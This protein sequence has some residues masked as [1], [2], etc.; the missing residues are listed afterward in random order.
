MRFVY[1]DE[2]KEFIKTKFQDHS[3]VEVTRMFNEKFGLDKTRNQLK[4]MANN[5]GI[6]CGGRRGCFGYRKTL[7]TEE[8]MAFVEREYQDISRDDLL[9]RLNAKYDLSL[10]INQLIAFLKNNKITSGRTGRFEKG[11]KPA[12]NARPKGPN[13]TSFSKGHTPHNA[14]PIGTE[15]NNY[16]YVEVKV[17]EPNTWEAKQR[18]VYKEF[19]GDLKESDVVRFVD[20]DRMNFSPDNLVKVSRAQ[21]A[22]LSRIGY[23]SQPQLLRPTILAVSH[24][25][26]RIRVIESNEDQVV[27]GAA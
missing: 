26:E 13:K 1:T 6:R 9:E 23:L 17:A 14:L 7:L 5:Y 22:Y 16:G 4:S 24:L 12:P 11:H 19:V 20:G 3:L 25:Q 15:R 10:T 21:H 2:H 8:Q 27:A 18:L